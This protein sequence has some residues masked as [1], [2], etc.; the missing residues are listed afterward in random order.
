ME[1][2]NKDLETYNIA[3]FYYI[4]CIKLPSMYDSLYHFCSDDKFYDSDIQRFLNSMSLEESELKIISL[5]KNNIDPEQMIEE[6]RTNHLTDQ[7][8][9]SIFCSRFSDEE[10]SLIH[11][12]IG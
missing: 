12:H 9:L 5:L 10:Q 6:I 1:T 2:I 8:Y 11:K 4:L 7:Y 3:R